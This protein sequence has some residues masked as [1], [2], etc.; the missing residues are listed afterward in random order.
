MLVLGL[1]YCVIVS[2]TYTYDVPLAVWSGKNYI[3]GANVGISKSLTSTD[4]EIML[5]S[6]IAYEPSICALSQYIHTDE[7]PEVIVLFAEAQLR[8]EQLSTNAESLL[9]FRNI[10][11]TA[12]SSLQAPFIDMSSAFDIHVMN[13]VRD[14]QTVSGKIFYFG[15]GTTLFNDIL[16]LEENTVSSQISKIEDIL[17]KNSKIY[18]NGKTDFII[19]YISTLEGSAKFTETDNIISE[20]HNLISSH[21]DNYLCVYTALAYDNPEFNIQFVTGIPV[22][23]RYFLQDTNNTNNTNATNGTVPVFRQY[24][25]GWF[26]ELFLT[27]FL[28]VPLLIIGTYAI[29]SIQTPL[30]EDKK[31]N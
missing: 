26:W 17:N 11:S 21:T 16:R 13:I 30:F 18:S 3:S 2:A 25:G 12:K 23:K 31:K 14:V 19:V 4:V 15:K 20:V 24:F 28:L 8:S 22:A 1:L 10:L 7:H 6:F 5:Q 9:K 27:M 29:D